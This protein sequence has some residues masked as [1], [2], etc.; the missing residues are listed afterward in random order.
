M[1]PWDSARAFYFIPVQDAWTLMDSFT[2][3]AHVKVEYSFHIMR[4]TTV[5]PEYPDTE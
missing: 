5:Y 3:P 1:V 2:S 4:I